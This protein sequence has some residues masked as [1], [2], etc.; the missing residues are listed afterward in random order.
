MEQAVLDQA[1]EVIQEKITQK[2]RENN[3]VKKIIDENQVPWTLSMKEVDNNEYLFGNKIEI[4]WSSYEDLPERKCTFQRI[5][6]DTPLNITHQ[7]YG[8]RLN[9]TYK[10]VSG[11]VSQIS[12]TWKYNPDGD[13]QISVKDFTM[14]DFVNV[15]TI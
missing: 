11:W 2:I 12:F 14:Q 13:I 6:W 9:L 15:K 7:K 1:R 8:Q 10:V 5:T 4:Q 3:F